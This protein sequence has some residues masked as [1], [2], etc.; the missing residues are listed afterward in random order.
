MMN[1]DD[2]WMEEDI[3]EDRQGR[4]AAILAARR[5]TASK[6]EPIKLRLRLAFERSHG[7]SFACSGDQAHGLAR[8]NTAAILAIL[9][10]L[11]SR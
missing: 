2:S 9:E 1:D 11:E 6:L 8:A 3:E 4:L 7:E 10:Y 5:E